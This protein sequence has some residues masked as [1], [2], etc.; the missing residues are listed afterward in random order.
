MGACWGD[1]A[2]ESALFPAMCIDKF[3]VLDH[4]LSIEEDNASRVPALLKSLR[5]CSSLYLGL[6]SPMRSTD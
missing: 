5:E 6:L 2:K 4:Q 1:K 3:G